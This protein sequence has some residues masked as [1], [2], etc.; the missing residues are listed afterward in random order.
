[1]II[2]S[3]GHSITP[4]VKLT[5]KPDAPNIE[6]G[7]GVPP[8]NFSSENI[9]VPIDSAIRALQQKKAVI[10]SN[11]LVGLCLRI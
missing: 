9:L 1:V 6:K 8:N 2:N 3:S 5:V 4:Q 10:P 11:N 7:C